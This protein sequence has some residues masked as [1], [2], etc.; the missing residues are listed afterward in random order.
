MSTPETDAVGTVR[1]GFRPNLPLAKFAPG[2]WAEFGTG[3]TFPSDRIIGAEHPV[4]GAV[5][6]TP[7]ALTAAL[8]PGAALAAAE[9]FSNGG[10]PCP[11]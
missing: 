8:G 4:I 5:P 3:R 1:A 9:R 2:I 11:A 10:T 6:G 7:A